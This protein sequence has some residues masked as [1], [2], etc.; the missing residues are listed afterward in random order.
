MYPT[1]GWNKTGSDT[2][3]L[4]LRSTRSQVRPISIWRWNR[5][6]LLQ[7]LCVTFFV[8][9]TKMFHSITVFLFSLS[10]KW[11]SF[12]F[13]DARCSTWTLAFCARRCTI[14]PLQ[15]P[16][17]SCVKRRTRRYCMAGLYVIQM[18]AS[19]HLLAIYYL[20]LIV[21]RLF[22]FHFTELMCGRRGHHFC[23]IIFQ[24]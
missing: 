17:T 4:S 1:F 15:L 9:E 3:F 11:M 14:Y 22:L 2:L 23:C 19:L 24:K 7:H 12:A 16:N 5:W 21:R 10:F 8:L 20:A 18:R 13:A 6:D